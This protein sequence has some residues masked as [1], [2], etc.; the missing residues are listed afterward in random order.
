MERNATGPSLRRVLAV[1]VNPSPQPTANAPGRK[2]SVKYKSKPTLIEAIQLK[3]NVEALGNQPGDW[4][5]QYEDGEC[6]IMTND[7]FVKEYEAHSTPIINFPLMP[8]DEIYRQMDFTNPPKI[9][10]H[11]DK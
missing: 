10:C 6:S 4:F 11:S 5:I 2:P 8:R 3:K 9:T 1:S 7:E